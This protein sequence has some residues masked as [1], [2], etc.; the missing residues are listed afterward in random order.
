[1][2]FIQAIEFTTTRISEFQDLVDEWIAKSGDRRTPARATLAAD[3]DRPNTYLQIVEFPSYEEAMRNSAL[4]E[5][6]EF[7]EKA[8]RLV[9]A[10][11]VYRNLAVQR[12]DDFSAG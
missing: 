7:A 12:V 5:T 3:Q 8:T 9:D 6:A 4:P 1:M 2:T 10:G 11:P